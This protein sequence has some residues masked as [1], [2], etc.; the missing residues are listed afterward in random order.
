MILILYIAARDYMDKE[1]S[2]NKSRVTSYTN[3][4][5][6]TAINKQKEKELSFLNLLH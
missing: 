6:R 4:I 3:Y 1:K 5:Y 2:K